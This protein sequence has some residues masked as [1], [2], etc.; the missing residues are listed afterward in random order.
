M[1]GR[2]QGRHR[3]RSHGLQP[4]DTVHG[5]GSLYRFYEAYWAPLV[6]G[7]SPLTSVIPWLVRQV[8]TPL[9]IVGS[10][11]RSATGCDAPHSTDCGGAVGCT[12]STGPG[13]RRPH[14]ADRRLRRI[15]GADSP[16][17]SCQ[18]QTFRQFRRFVGKQF[19]HRPD[20]SVRVDRIA[21][22]R[23]LYTVGAEFAHLFV[24]VT[25]IGTLAILLGLAGYAIWLGL[26]WVWS[27]GFAPLACLSSRGP[28]SSQTEQTPAN[29]LA[30]LSLMLSAV[31]L[32][33]SSGRISATSSSGARTKETDEK[34]AKRSAILGQAT[35]VLEHVLADRRC[36][37]VVV[38]AHSMGTAIAMDA[39]LQ[40]GRHNR[41]RTADNPIRSPLP[42][43]KIVV[44]VT[45]RGS[46]IDKI[47]FFFESSESAYHRYIRVSRASAAINPDPV[48]EEPQAPYSTGSTSGIAPIWLAAR[49]DA[50]ASTA[51]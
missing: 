32:A 5:V 44:F 51:G 40:L 36:A 34:H 25:L 50:G 8:M 28:A 1:P 13:R 9:R 2:G 15:R 21:Q 37:R 16:D 3:V 33:R 45:M 46:P 42:L 18:R 6:A 35:L 41:A 19:E 24:L 17:G 4:T 49:S 26:G 31:G 10:P 23:R 47:H 30:M 43:E 29:L 38:V 27:R 14:K 11:W 20:T 48:G 22:I 39:L 12:R 7:G